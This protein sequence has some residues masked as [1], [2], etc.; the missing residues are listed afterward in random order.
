[1]IARFTRVATTTK[2][3]MRRVVGSFRSSVGHGRR[4]P[5]APL[6]AVEPQPDGDE[7]QPHDE[8]R[9]EDDEDEDPDVGIGEKAEEVERNQE[10]EQQCAR[11]GHRHANGREAIPQSGSQKWRHRPALFLFQAEHV[12]D[13]RVEI[14]DFTFM[15]FSR[16]CS[17][18]GSCRLSVSPRGSRAV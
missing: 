8:Q 14:F 6:P 16:L 18:E 3:V 7:Q 2:V 13:E 9:R 1:M 10:K 11:G 17:R 15:M 4:G 12:R 5:I